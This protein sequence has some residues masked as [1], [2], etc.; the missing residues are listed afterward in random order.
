[1]RVSVVICTLNRAD[2]LGATLECLRRQRHGD[3]EVIVVNGPST[4]HTLDAL[5]PWRDHIRYF[6]NPLRN[7]SVSRNIG[8]RATV[9]DLI[10]FIDDDAL[11][12]PEWLTQAI[13]AFDDPEV[14]G[15]GGIVFDHTGMAL[16][17]RYAATNRLLQTS[18][19][20]HDSALQCFPG[21]FQ[22]PYLQGTNQVYR[23]QPLLDVGGFD[24]RIF[25][26]GD[27]CDICA[28]LIDAGW[29]IVQLPTS[30][31]HHKY[32]PSGI[33]DHQR[34]TTVFTPV[35]HDHTY[36]SLRHGTLYM[37]EQEI[38]PHINDFMERCVA[39]TQL[40]ED[41][42]RLPAG[43]SRNTRAQCMAAFADGLLEGREWVG[44][45]LPKIEPDPNEF[46]PFPRL[47]QA[48]RRSLVFV[49]AS[50]TGNLEGGIARMFSDL[51]PAM[52]AR[53]HDVRVITR[54]VGPAAVDLEDGVWVHRIA[55]PD[56]PQGVGVAP[57][58]L[59]PIN[60]FAT[61][62]AV[63]I[64]R[65]REW[66]EPEIVFVPLW[67]VEG[68]GVLRAT[69][70]PVAVHVSTPLAI[71]GP[72]A[73]YFNNEDTDPIEMR[74][75]LELEAEVLD[76]ADAFQANTTAV[77]ETIRSDYGDA[78]SSD[79]WDVINLGLRDQRPGQDGP[80]AGGRTR[81]FF[82]GRFESR[83][84][85][86]TLLGAMERI[87]PERP[88]VELVVG[89]EDRP[90]VPGAE[91]VGRAWLA[92]HRGTSWI[93]RVT[94]LGVIDDETL[95]EEYAK[96][97]LVV[98]PSR[99]ES[100]GLVMVEALMHG[101]PLV[102]CD[103]SGVREV[104]SNGV[105]GILVAPGDVDE[106]EAAI[107]RLL[108]DPE[109][110]A[111]LAAAGRRRFDE[112]LSVERFAERFERFLHQLSTRRMDAGHDVLSTG[113]ELDIDLAGCSAATIII[114]AA[115]ESRVRIDSP[116]RSFTLCRGERRRVRIATAPA[117]ARVVVQ[118]GEVVVERIV[119]IDGDG[120]DG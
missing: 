69:D 90:L 42:G 63:E 116:A 23:R 55:V 32:L 29:V 113:D 87:L 86:D 36:F 47:P 110:A 106:L 94:V 34:I 27:D 67:D 44:R 46:L 28:R 105:D 117:R 14:A 59:A 91:L 43:S 108:D 84:G 80:P 82:V 115:E 53:G 10:A 18:L 103:T 79:R 54:A 74:R 88:D 50:Y 78:C 31:I 95:H 33:R 81:I 97:D 61:A 4:D 76:T 12:E 60:A 15:A 38:L 17:Y 107:R 71:I 118:W 100:F 7:L 72:L 39:D 35:M 101:K 85:I 96:A 6:D 73:G 41:A 98:L 111:S 30:P 70:L 120:S 112:H 3:F 114:R 77:I 40:H 99:Y 45:P 66:T 20:E 37:T 51:A 65:I 2:A 19:S 49:S 68:I 11:P 26:Y 62:A 9:G 56:L 24:E 58:T 25:F 64:Q 22:F 8:I 102:S 57:D 1:V 5:R 83:K 13:P 89:G 21:T 93:D 92:E 119:T 104:V 75:L 48:G 109:L 52:A 16:Q